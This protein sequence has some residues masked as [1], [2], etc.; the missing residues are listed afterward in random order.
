MT[1][2]SSIQV[3]EASAWLNSHPVRH[4][5]NHDRSE[6]RMVKY[7]TTVTASKARN[8]MPPAPNRDHNAVILDS[9]QDIRCRE[10]IVRLNDSGR[11]KI[12]QPIE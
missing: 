11:P 12:V 4:L 7:N 2:E 1:G 10:G 8:M 3:T 6:W 5:V 9:P